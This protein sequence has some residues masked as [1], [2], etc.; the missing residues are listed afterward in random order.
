MR[1]TNQT[2]YAV[3]ML[4]F[5]AGKEGLTTTKEIA[6]F[7][8]LPEKFMLKVLYGLGKTGLIETVRGRGG[9]FKLAVPA[10][11]IRLGDVVHTIENDFELAECFSEGG[12]DCPLMTSCG[13]NEAL[14]KALEAFLEAL[15][16]YTIEDLATKEHNIGVLLR[17]NEALKVPF[18]PKAAKVH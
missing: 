9:G 14:S 17:L 10:D 2:Q 11:Q 12:G 8:D 15:N 13:L 3:R 1:L 6:Q 16:S 5:C 18:E 4:M 7:Y